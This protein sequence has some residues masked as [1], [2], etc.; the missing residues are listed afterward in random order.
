MSDAAKPL[1][2][3]SDGT[4]LL[5]IHHGTAQRL[6]E[7]LASIA[8]LEKSPEYF[9]EYRIS[10]ISLWNAAQSGWTAEKVVALLEDNARY[11][12]PKA[13][14]KKITDDM[15]KFGRLELVRR[16]D[17]DDHVVHAEMDSTG[18]GVPGTLV[19]KPREPGDDILGELATRRTL[20][21]FLKHPIREGD[22]S[23]GYVIRPEDRGALKIALIRVGY[24]LFD[25]AGF[26]DG[27]HLQVALRDTAPD[28]RSFALREYQSRAVSSFFAD[29]G[30]GGGSGVVVLPCGAGK[31]VIGIGIICELRTQTLIL[32][33]NITALRQ[34]KRE[35]LARTD[36]R[37]DQIAEYSAKEKT[38]A[39]ITIATYQIMSHRRSKTEEFSHLDLFAEHDW[40]LIIYDEV[41]LLPA[42]VFRFTADIQAR[43]RLG[44]TATLVR[45]D[46][47][48]YEVFTLI[49]PRVY[50]L[51]W[52]DL[53]QKGFIASV[54]CIEARIDLADDRRADYEATD[55]RHRFRLASENPRKMEW[56]HVLLKRHSGERILIIGQYLRQIRLVAL[57]T[58]APVITGQTP[59]EERDQLYAGFRDGRIP[60]LIVSKVGNHAIDLPD[61]AVAI[62]ISGT[63]GSRQEEAQRLGRILRPKSDGRSAYFY[64]LVT[65][66]T[67][68]QE[69]AA[70]RQ[71]FLMEQGYHYDIEE[72]VAETPV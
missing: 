33:P 10:P 69:F 60:V 56:L 50:E 58:G 42:P 24:P 70:R 68:D 65:R 45:E 29:E 12:V 31:T 17:L 44:L 36:L 61:A 8:H 16:D 40:G 72:Q 52:R 13:L 19:L 2:V 14:S 25:N 38:I 27:A 62:Q 51:P 49:G 71:R 46:G 54:K 23:P 67:L 47:K 63:F 35:I 9:H 4:L 7:P 37:D 57:D 15:A 5:E 28:G 21:N 53:E 43:R 34:W 64:S 59:H 6:R 22:G 55:R 11:P 30:G 1:V 66:D 3:Q 20:E 18:G 41:H 32:A 48:E 39:P 26:L